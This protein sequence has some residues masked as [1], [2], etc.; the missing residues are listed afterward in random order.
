MF[1][2]EIDWFF[3]AFISAFLFVGLSYL[4]YFRVSRKLFSQELEFRKEINQNEATTILSIEGLGI[5]KK[6]QMQFTENDY[7]QID[8]IIDGTNY[9]TFAITRKRNNMDKEIFT[10]RKDA[11][12][13]LD[14]NLDAKFHKHFSLFVHNRNDNLINS[15]GKIFYEIKKPLKE[16][17]K[18]IYSETFS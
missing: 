1:M 17:L 13:D 7:S 16:I 9:S 4:V 3:I 8:M 18:A 5:I 15:T 12:L 14:V 11:I 6:I 10:G 2:I